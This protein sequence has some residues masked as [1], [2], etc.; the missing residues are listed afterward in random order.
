[1]HYAANQFDKLIS[2]QNIKE[3]EPKR[4]ER[5]AHL[6]VSFII[7]SSLCFI[8]IICNVYFF[9]IRLS[10]QQPDT[11]DSLMSSINVLSIT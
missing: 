4:K 6:K 2:S 7:N 8:L 10:C 3:S 11:I 9:I 5:C 1:M